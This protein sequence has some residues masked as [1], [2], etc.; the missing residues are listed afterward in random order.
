MNAHLLTLAD[1]HA[2]AP[3]V[4]DVVFGPD[5]DFDDAPLWH[6]TIWG[7]LTR[8]GEDRPAE[9]IHD[10]KRAGTDFTVKE[11]DGIASVRNPALDLRTSAHER[12]ARVCAIALGEAGAGWRIDAFGGCWRLTDGYIC[13]KWPPD[14][15]VYGTAF[16]EIPV[17]AG[18]P[19]D[20]AASFLTAL[21]L[22]LAPRIAA[23]KDAK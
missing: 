9:W 21:T 14:G 12:I 11:W 17:V 19:W 7:R 16:T 18:A 10:W 6:P 4:L 1:L 5:G 15:S 20:S 13:Y 22:A 2:A 3:G 23:L 8:W